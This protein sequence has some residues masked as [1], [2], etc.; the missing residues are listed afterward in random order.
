MAFC[1]KEA[2]KKATEELGY[3]EHM[4]CH[5][6][7]MRNF[8][9]ILYIESQNHGMVW[10]RGDLKDHLVPTPLPWAGTYFH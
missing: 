10:V 9:F 4:E 1:Q 7:E 6:C 2:E 3:C 5:Q 8:T